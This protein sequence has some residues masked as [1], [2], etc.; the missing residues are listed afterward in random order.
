MP[1]WKKVITSGSDATLNSIFVTTSVT[2]SAFSASAGFT[3]SVLGTASYVTG[4]VHT[5]AN[6]ALSASY[7]LTASYALNAVAGG[8][9]GAGTTNRHAKFTGATSIGDSLI[10]DDGT[11]V[12]ITGSSIT[13]SGSSTVFRVTGSVNSLGGFTGSISASSLQGAITNAQLANSSVT[14]GST[15]ISLGTSAT[16]IAGIISLTTTGVTASFISASAGITGS[17][18]GTASYASNA[19]LLDGVHLADIIGTGSSATTQRITGSLILSGSTTTELRVLGEQQITGSLNVLN[20][21]IAQSIT[22]SLL[23]T[24]SY[25]TGSIFTGVNQA[26]SASYALTASYSIG[27][28]MTKAGSVAA[29]SFTGT[30]RTAAVTFTTAFANTSYAINVT[31]EDNRTWMIQSKATTGF[32]IN[33]NSSVALAG[34]TYWIATAYGEN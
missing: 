29:G 1:S 33:S 24:A 4:S 13:V 7:A 15:A 30:P 9:T 14:V 28:L 8:L 25:V 3:G 11:N 12:Q 21:I 5:S 10:Y 27:E 23:G 20:G 2:A 32:T 31:G 6:P 16:T 26:A 22:A 18:L 17:V 19:D 34:T